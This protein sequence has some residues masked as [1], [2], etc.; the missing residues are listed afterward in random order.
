[1]LNPA[2][3]RHV[4]E[5][6]EGIRE[7]PTIPEVLVRIW[8]LVDDPSSSARDLQEVVMLDPPLAARVLRLANSPYYGGKTNIQDIRSAITVLGFDVIRNLAVCLAVTKRL[9][10]EAPR[11]R[12]LDRRALWRH[13][14][15]TAVVSREVAVALRIGHP[16][17][18]F[19]GGLLHDVGMY[20]IGLVRPGI[21]APVVERAIA[22]R[23]P[24]A[25][26]ER[27][28][29]GYDHAAMGSA[30]AARWNFPPRIRDVIGR[31][32]E[33]M[34]TEHPG[35]VEVVAFA[36]RQAAAS[37]QF[38][39]FP[40]L[41]EEGPEAQHLRN[42]GITPEWVQQHEA[43]FGAKIGEAQEFMNLI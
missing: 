38:R 31:H 18:S 7:L 39:V 15:A 14:V 11:D 8:Q 13:C 43:P 19:T 26:A 33:R 24:L 5:I 2:V 16:E 20:V 37:G 1:M 21:Y 36:D 12:V 27:Q 29:L 9:V 25:D 3:E 35:T 22:G 42:L 40:Q 23:T 41:H 4:E 17:E 32:H 28:V 34:A 10:E 30:F 6:L